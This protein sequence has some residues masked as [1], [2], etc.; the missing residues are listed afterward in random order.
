ML[1]ALVLLNVRGLIDVTDQAVD[2]VYGYIEATAYA[3]GTIS[4]FLAFAVGLPAIPAAEA[5]DE[6][7][8]DLAA[9]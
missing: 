1:F 8:D 4:L 9:A 7:A 3:A 5:D 2:E 6:P